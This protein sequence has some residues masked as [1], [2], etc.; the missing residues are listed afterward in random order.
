MSIFPVVGGEEFP[1]SSTPKI[2]GHIAFNWNTNSLELQ[3][4]WTYRILGYQK[5]GK[6]TQ[7]S[8]FQFASKCAVTLQEQHRPQHIRGTKKLHQ[9]TRSTQQDPDLENY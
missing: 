1:T 8:A 5:H 7:N 9:E 3:M 6:Y 4:I 2:H